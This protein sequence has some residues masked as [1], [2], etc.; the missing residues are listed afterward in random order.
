MIM[1]NPLL[2]LAHLAPQMSEA[3]LRVILALAQISDGRPE[4]VATYSDIGLSC[5]M[6][7]EGV[8]RGVKGEFLGRF[9]AR[10]GQR[11]I[12]QTVSQ[13]DRNANEVDQNANEVDRLSYPQ[14]VDNCAN[15]NEVDQNA[16]EVDCIDGGE[17][18]K[19]GLL[20][21]PK[22][23]PSRLKCQPSRPNEGATSHVR[24]RTSSS[25]SS[26]NTSSK[27]KKEKKEEETRT[28]APARNVRKV[29][30]TQLKAWLAE[31]APSDDQRKAWRLLSVHA[32]VGPTS[33]AMA[34]I[35]ANTPLEGADGIRA[36]VQTH[37]A[38]PE[39]YPANHLITAIRNGPAPVPSLEEKPAP[40][41]KGLAKMEAELAEW[42]HLLGN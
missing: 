17:V 12:W 4:F 1:K 14:I 21:R 39:K 37:Q 29:S 13:V 33:V 20:S 5:K 36:H 31:H 18:Y 7:R 34:D 15:A 42:G 23:Q 22:C 9:F 2:E 25:S 41:A 11:S 32:N 19:N 24:A 30:D 8:A 40:A 6:S 26:L 35:L 3:E 10:N 27:E 16:N 28:P 38:H